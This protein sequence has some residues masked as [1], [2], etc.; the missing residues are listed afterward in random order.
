MN[1]KNNLYLDACSTTP[2]SKD[3]I[4]EINNI[5]L[6]YF[7]NPSSIHTNGV[8]ASTILESS[9]MS[10]STIL[11]SRIEEI[12]FTS[13]ATESINL[14][15]KGITENMKTGRIITS[16]V[17]HPAVELAVNSLRK[18]GWDIDYLPVDI[19]GNF[20]IEYLDKLLRPPTSLVSLIW[21]QS[22][23][24][25]VEPI[26]T[27]GKLCKERNIIFHAD[28]TQILPNSLINFR[29]LPVDMV[30]ISG[31][32]FRGPKGIGLLLVKSNLISQICSQHYGGG[33]ESGLRSGTEAIS[34]IA[35]MKVAIEKLENNI[36][37]SDQK[38]F[39]K[40]SKVSQITRNLT[41][42]LCN[43]NGVKLFGNDHSFNRLPNHISLILENKNG[44]PISSR[45]FVRKMSDNGVSISSGTACS[46]GSSKASQALLATGL[47][48]KYINSII[49]LS[50]GNWIQLDDIQQILYKFE[51]TLYN[52]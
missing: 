24:G 4:D 11:N 7:G 39:F 5:N 30:S 33:Q 13:G 48:Q 2:M 35:G 23:I 31:H 6:N 17:E 15:I 19:N 37:Y 51:K 40:S 38:T 52:F 22:E 16:R 10:I 25:T 44:N 42:T 46:N 20:K 34:L 45:D 27:V 8:E 1:I 36:Y 12:I 49:R 50:L 26:N 41:R 9:R 29:D 3:V 18:L 47:D 14:A 21:G 32:K 43:I 28:A